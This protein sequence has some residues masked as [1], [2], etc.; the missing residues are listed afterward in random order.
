M[1]SLPE[2]LLHSVNEME[3]LRLQNDK[4]TPQK[5]QKRGTYCMTYCICYIPSQQK[6][7]DEET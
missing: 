7:C 5:Y 4:K 6:L 3:S 1:R 2:C